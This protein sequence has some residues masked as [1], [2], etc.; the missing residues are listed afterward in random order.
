MT[1]PEPFTTP[2][3]AMLPWLVWGTIGLVGIFVA[4]ALVRLWGWRQQ[5]RGGACGGIDLD[6]LRRQRDAGEI[7]QDDYETI[8]ARLAGADARTPP[9]RAADARTPP[10]RAERN[11][12][13]SIEPDSDRDGS[14]DTGETPERSRADGEA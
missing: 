3:E 5:Q 9:E 6:R 7:S 10:E 2:L 13:P 8:R 4:L 12:E 1:S 14:A 11:D